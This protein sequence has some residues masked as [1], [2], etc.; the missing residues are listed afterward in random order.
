MTLSDDRV[1]PREPTPYERYV[2]EV[3]ALGGPLASI[4]D[5]M[6][7]N[8]G[9]PTSVAEILGG[10]L[11]DTLAPLR[12]D[13]DDAALAAGAALLRD[14]C[15]IVCAEILLAPLDRAARRA[16]ARRGRGACG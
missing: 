16:A 8:G 15:D 4:A 1:A 7:R 12:A 3:V 11:R 13:H 9:T 6:I 10:L 14:T 2:D 5:H